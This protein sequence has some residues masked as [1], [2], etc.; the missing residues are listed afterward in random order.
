MPLL[1]TFFI[2]KSKFLSAFTK[3][4]QNNDKKTRSPIQEIRTK[5]AVSENKGDTVRGINKHKRWNIYLS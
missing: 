5:N 2:E 1:K 4:V 3:L